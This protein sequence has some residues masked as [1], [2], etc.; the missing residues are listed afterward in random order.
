MAVLKHA[1]NAGY[2]DFIAYRTETALDVL[3][4]RADFQLLTLDLT[5]PTD[6]FARGR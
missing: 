1:V 5:F 2:R 6:P 4:G 3:R